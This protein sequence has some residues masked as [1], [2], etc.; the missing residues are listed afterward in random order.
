MLVHCWSRETGGWPRLVAS[1]T[2]SS[3]S[4]CVEFS[5]MACSRA[6]EANHVDRPSE[7]KRPEHSSWP[8]DTELADK[9]RHTRDLQI[10]SGIQRAAQTV[11]DVYLKRTCLR[12]TSAS[13]TLG[14]LN[15]YAL[16]KST[17]SLTHLTQYHATGLQQSTIPTNTVWNMINWLFGIYNHP[18]CKKLSSGV[19]AWLS[20]WSEVQTCIWPS[21]CHCH[22]LSLASVKSRLV[23]PSG[24]SSLR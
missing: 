5:T 1:W 12:V 9:C 10:L 21:L 19:L 20:V 23:L 14:V 8:A 11:L 6:T 16:H 4:F 15:D 7:L 22:S 3:C 18:A 17:H 13:S 24:T 2:R